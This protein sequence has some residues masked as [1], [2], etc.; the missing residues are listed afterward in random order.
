MDPPRD[1][2]PLMLLSITTSSL[3]YSVFYAIFSKLL[4]PPPFRFQRGCCDFSPR[5]VAKVTF[6]SQSHRDRR[7]FTVHRDRPL[8]GFLPSLAAEGG[9]GIICTV[10]EAPIGMP[11]RTC[12]VRAAQLSANANSGGWMAIVVTH[13]YSSDIHHD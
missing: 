13:L 7:L 6:Y 4:Y 8:I 3:A 5:T 10:M 12:S 9:G 1:T 2:V 11:Y